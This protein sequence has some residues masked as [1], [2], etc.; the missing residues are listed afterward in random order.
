MNTEHKCLY[1]IITSKNII[2]LLII[3]FKFFGFEIILGLIIC[4]SLHLAE[5]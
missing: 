3:L 4:L 2:S 1:V 5:Y